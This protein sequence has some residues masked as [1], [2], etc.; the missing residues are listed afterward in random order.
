MSVEF[1]GAGLSYSTEYLPGGEEDKDREPIG[2][3]A[4]KLLWLAEVLASKGGESVPFH[5]LYV[6][7]RILKFPHKELEVNQPG[8]PACFGKLRP[9]SIAGHTAAHSLS[10]W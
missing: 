7:T 4:N 3:T 2:L 5:L 9:L 10:C 8:Q 1:P 6:K